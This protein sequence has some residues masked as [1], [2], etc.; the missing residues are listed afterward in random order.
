M[1]S[2]ENHIAKIRGVLAPLREAA[3][4]EA[5]AACMNSL[6]RAD[7][8]A[9]H[10]IE[11]AGA[12]AE[13]LLKRHVLSSE[14][15]SVM[16]DAEPVAKGE[17][18]RVQLG[19]S[20]VTSPFVLPAPSEASEPSPVGLAVAAAVGAVGGMMALTPAA[21]SLLDMRDTGLFVGA[22][23]GAFLLVL[24]MYCASTSRWLRWFPLARHRLRFDRV[25][26]QDTVL[27]AIGQ[28]LDGAIVAAWVLLAFGRDAGTV[29]ADR[30]A[31]LY[32]LVARVR[33][34]ADVP[35]KNLSFAVQE[36]QQELRNMGFAGEGAKTFQ[37]E[38]SMA[39]RYDAFG[40]IDPGDPV[41]VEREPVLFEDGVREKGLVRKARNR[42]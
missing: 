12:A 35:S 24:V 20:L 41:I 7:F 9:R 4:R 36:L 38:A 34:L 2:P 17:A 21:R 25:A 5:L 10:D 31:L 14:W 13:S 18:A 22:P 8:P 23:L 33:I 3:A 15:L 28:W 37:W 40:H 11:A 27:Q 30:E 42:G 16:N 26:Y 1:T 6:G 19:L 39:E 29:R 32:G